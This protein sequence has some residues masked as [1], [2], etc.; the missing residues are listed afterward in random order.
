MADYVRRTIGPVGHPC[1]AADATRREAMAEA[2]RHHTEE[3]AQAATKEHKKETQGD[4]R[5]ED[6]QPKVWACWDAN[7]A[8]ARRRWLDQEK[9]DA[10]QCR[11]HAG[12]REARQAC[13]VEG[14]IVWTRRG[15]EGGPS[16]HARAGDNK[17]CAVGRR[18]HR[19]TCR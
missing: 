3:V 17:E 10:R 19:T 5:T 8:A 16:N 13:Q 6:E 11:I 12:Y 18:W 7:M 2:W 1:A 15:D 14:T 9:R 4:R